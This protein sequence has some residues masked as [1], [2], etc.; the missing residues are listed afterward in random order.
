MLRVGRVW[1]ASECQE[2]SA[3]KKAFRHGAA[4]FRKTAGLAREKSFADRVALLHPGLNLRNL[5]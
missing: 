2:T 1:A 3:A 4:G 5:A